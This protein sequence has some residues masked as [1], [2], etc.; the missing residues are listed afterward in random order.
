MAAYVSSG[1]LSMIQRVRSMTFS[2]CN[3]GNAL[4]NLLGL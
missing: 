1:I 3:E 2:A 4:S